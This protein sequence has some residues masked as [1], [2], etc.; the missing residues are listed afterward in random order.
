MNPTPGVQLRD[1]VAG[2]FAAITGI[3]AHHVA[4]GSASF[5]LER[6]SEDDMLERWTNVGAEQF[7]WIVAVE[8]GRTVGYAYAAA[9]RP[10]CAYRYSVEDSVYVA[11]DAHGR[12]IGSR[13]LDALIERCTTRGDRQMIAVI[14]DSANIA[15]IALHARAGFVEAGRLRDV[16]RKFERW[17][18]IVLMQRGLGDGSQSAPT[19]P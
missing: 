18:D 8:N 10:R 14:G 19:R 5:E 17:L 9:Y 2:D 7:P 12:R 4:F 1:A 16:G 11:P 6:P 15:S 13:L 3:Y